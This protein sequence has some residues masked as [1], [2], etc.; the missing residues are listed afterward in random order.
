MNINRRLWIFLMLSLVL[1]YGCASENDK[2]VGKKKNASGN[3]TTVSRT[4]VNRSKKFIEDSTKA[5]AIDADGANSVYAID[6][7]DDSDIDILSA[8]S[9]DNT[10]AWYENDGLE[11]F[12]THNVS[13]LAVGVA[14]IYAVDVEDDGDIDV[15]AAAAD[16]TVAWYENDGSQ[17]FTRKNITTSAKAAVSVY[18]SDIDKDGDIDV[19][20]ASWDDSKI[21]WYENDGNTTN[22]SFT[23][24]TITT[25]AK[26]ASSVYASDI[27]GDGHIDVLSASFSDNT[28]AWYEN[29]G[30][31]TNPNFTNEL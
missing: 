30:N 6:I 19:L 13:I 17:N 14:S 24:H 11:I 22:P 5:I 25:L 3:N 1:V 12:T 9:E 16:N 29:D 7:D 8:S 23:E 4:L 21:A 15:L 2:G 10:I 20:P 27:N 26:Q 31:T 28:I 18:A